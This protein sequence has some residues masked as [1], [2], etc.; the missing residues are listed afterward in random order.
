MKRHDQENNVTELRPGDIVQITDERPG[1]LGALLMVDEVKSWGIQGFIHHVNSFEE[2]AE[3]KV[4]AW[5]L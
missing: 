3:E 1:L 2:L 5:T 4:Q